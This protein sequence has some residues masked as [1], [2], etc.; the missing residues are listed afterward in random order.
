[1]QKMQQPHQ[2]KRKVLIGDM[3]IQVIASGSSGNAY[4]ISDGQTALLLDAGIPYKEIQ[5]ALHFRIRDLSGCLVTHS[6]GDHAKAAQC[7][8]DAAVDVYSSQGTIDACKLTSLRIHA[9]KALQEFTVGSFEILPFDVQ[10]DAPEPLGFL[11]Y[12]TLTREKLLYFTDTYY[13]R[14]K[15]SG[16]THIMGECNYSIELAKASVR[17][18][19]I[20]AEML[21]RLVKSHMSLETFLDF[22]RANDLSHVRQIYLLHLSNNN[23]DEIMFRQAVQ[24]LTGTEVYI[25]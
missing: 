25:C 23:S 5:K 2:A 7:L 15:F 17:E 19:R 10:H 12:S 22:L 20:P 16:L 3:D 8:A 6:H 1:M 13:V 9:V 24:E 11:I 4:R 14:Y 18:G 21:P